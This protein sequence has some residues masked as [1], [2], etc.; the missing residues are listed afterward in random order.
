[1]APET[2]EL[3]NICPTIEAPLRQ[4]PVTVDPVLMVPEIGLYVDK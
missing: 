3:V 4:L 2:V 1:M